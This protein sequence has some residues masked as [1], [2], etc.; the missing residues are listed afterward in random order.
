MPPASARAKTSDANSF[1]YLVRA[2]QLFVEGAAERLKAI[3]APALIDLQPHRRAV[4]GRSVKRTA[5]AIK[6]NG[7]PVELVEL[8]GNRGHLDGVVSIKQAE[9]E[10]AAFLAK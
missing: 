4:P 6:A 1:I 10:I 5:D 8:D 9:K 3:K 7:A 2:N